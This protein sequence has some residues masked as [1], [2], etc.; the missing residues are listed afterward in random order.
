MDYNYVT[1]AFLFLKIIQM[2]IR[3]VCINIHLKSELVSMVTAPPSPL[4]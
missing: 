1:R 4:C 2:T 3:F